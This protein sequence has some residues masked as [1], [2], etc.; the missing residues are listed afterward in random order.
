MDYS[1]K[2]LHF[3]DEGLSLQKVADLQNKV[4]ADRGGTYTPENFAFWYLKNPVGKVISFNAFYCDELVAHYAC[5]PIMMSIN[6]RISTGLLDMATVTHPNHRGKGLFKTLAQATYSFAKDKGFEF[7]VGVANG[8]SFPGYM[9]YFDFTF[10]SQLDV[11]WGWGPVSIPSKAYSGFWTKESLN[12]RLGNHKYF[13]SKKYAYGK[14]GNYPL[15]KTLMGVFSEEQLVSLSVK[16]GAKK[17]R[18][19]NLYVGIGADL[20]QGHYFNFPKFVK[21]SPFNLIFMDLTG[22]KLPPVNKDNIVYQL[23]DFDVA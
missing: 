23:I 11:K 15:I 2:Q 4:Y 21:H 22:G 14:Y 19:L 20:S 7:V 12:W 8:N 1:I 6:G 9:K 10:I 3:D 17:M 18:P 5:I 16:G 13:V